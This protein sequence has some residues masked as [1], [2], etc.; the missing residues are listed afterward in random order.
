M[1]TTMYSSHGNSTRQSGSWY[2]R[3]SN[4]RWNVEQHNAIAAHTHKS[5]ITVTEEMMACLHCTLNETE[6]K[7][8]DEADETTE[9]RWQ[10]CED[11]IY[12]LFA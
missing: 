6:G 3:I 1:A 11:C 8:T 10:L 7:G 2:N 9:A 4:R 12:V 5:I